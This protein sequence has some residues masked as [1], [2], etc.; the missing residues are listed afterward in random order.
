MHSALEH[1]SD[2]WDDKR[3]LLT[4]SLEAVAGMALQSAEV[5]KEADDKLAAE[6]RKVME[7]EQ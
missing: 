5:L 4:G 1:F 7:G 3:E 2:N 6:V